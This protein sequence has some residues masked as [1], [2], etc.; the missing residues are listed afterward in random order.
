LGS[1]LQYQVQTLD[2]LDLVFNSPRSLPAKVEGAT[3]SL[4]INPTGT[5]LFDAESGKRLI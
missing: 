2:G 5:Y 4:E 1:H 3:F